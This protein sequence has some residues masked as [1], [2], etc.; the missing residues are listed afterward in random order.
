MHVMMS[1]HKFFFF[2]FYKK[3]LNVLDRYFKTRQ[4]QLHKQKDMSQTSNFVKKLAATDRKTRDAAFD[5]LK[6]YLA[7]RSSTKLSLLEMEKLWKG[8]YYSMWLCDR[9]RPQERLAEDLGRLYSEVIPIAAFVQFVEA[10]WVIIIREW[11]N[12]DQWRV[13]KFYLL[14][15]RVLRHSIKQL[16][17]QKW[18]PKTVDSFLAV[19][20]KLPLSGDN[21]VSVSLPYHLCDI[22][23]DE[24]EVV[25]FEELKDTNEEL[26]ESEKKD[27]KK[28][29]ELV[30]QKVEIASE[31]PIKKL[32]SPFEKLNKN[33]LLKTLREK[34]K[35]DVLDDERLKVWGIFEDE[36]SESDDEW[37][38]FN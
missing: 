24:L 6:Q 13:D 3:R 7:S 8:L 5:S 18:A 27:M 2:Q 38:G 36:E 29:E 14:I 25:I 11:P 10:F 30:K 34:C 20:E 31:V 35:N 9:P 22:Y 19:Y 1:S 28:Y 23:I 16:K 17:S 4:K 12:I 37:E 33:A 26:E 32:I 21:S 15:R